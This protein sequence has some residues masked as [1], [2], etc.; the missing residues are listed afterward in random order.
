MLKDVPMLDDQQ[1]KR[2]FN[3]IILN[4]CLGMVSGSLFQNGFYLNYFTKLGISSAAFAMLAALPALLSMFLLIPFAFYSDRCGKKKLALVGQLLLIVNLVLMLTAGWWGSHLAKRIIIAA[5]LVSCVGGSLQGA[6]WFALL[7]PIIPKEI[8]GRFF[9]RLRVTFQSVS[10]LFTL[11]ITF[12]LRSSQTMAVFQSL[13]GLVLVASVL[14]FFTYARIPE[15]ENAT[16][17][18]GHREHLFKA[19]RAVLAVPGYIQY[20]G[21]IFL[22]TLF[23]AAIP[24]VFGLMQKDIFGFEPAQITLVGTFY[25]VGSMMGCWLGGR[26]VDRHGV[27]CVFRVTHMA[28]AVVMLAMLA[29]HWT[30]WPLMVHVG[31]CAW[32][33]S[34]IAGVAGVAATSQTLAL[35]P[36]ANKSLSTA[37]TMSLMCASVAFA[38][39]FVA[40]SI[41]WGIFAAEWQ[42]LGRTFTSYD[43]MLLAFAT[44]T[45]LMLITI[46]MIPPILKKS[47]DHAE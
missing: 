37:F 40:R 13:L 23:T 25:L 28:Y 45:A 1:R 6:S 17:E 42:M 43:S 5:L 46:G 35:I 4:Q 22:I 7:N 8:R 12:V 15:L 29:R 2:A 26:V 14:R 38:G 9:G 39:M 33:F 44:L 41:S 20:N 27:R 16:G 36:A 47:P 30:P 32:A 34:L 24:T 21:Y 31:G 18:S 3:I 10:I 11:L 19:L